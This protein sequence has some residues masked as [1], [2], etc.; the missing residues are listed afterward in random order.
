MYITSPSQHNRPLYRSF[1]LWVIFITGILITCYTAIEIHSVLSKEVQCSV[2]NDMLC[3]SNLMDKMQLPI[4]MLTATITLTGFWALMFRSNQTTQQIKATLDHNTFNNYVSHKKEFMAMLESFEEEYDC[5]VSKKASLYRK[6]FPQNNPKNMTFDG[7]AKELKS[8]T[9]NITK[10]KRRLAIKFSKINSRR[11]DNTNIDFSEHISVTDHFYWS[12]S[13]FQLYYNDCLKLNLA[14]REYTAPI[15]LSK[16]FHAAEKYIEELSDFCLNSS[17][18]INQDDYF[19]EEFLY[20]ME[21]YDQEAM[22][23]ML[24][25]K[26]VE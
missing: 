5:R 18:R 22:P 6:I 23:C 10:C 19:T 17:N 9:K 8:I 2:L 15:E 7:D 1:T 20:E 14:N 4:S 12:L 25:G 16:I 26:E 21:Y 3:I 13:S 11:S 24:H